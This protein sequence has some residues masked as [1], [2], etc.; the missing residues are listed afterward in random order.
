MTVEYAWSLAGLSGAIFLG[1][2][3][4]RIS[5]VG[6]ALVASP[7]LVVLLGPFNGILVINVF[8]VA[9]ALMVLVRVYREVEFTRALL[10]IVPAVIAIIPGSWVALHANPAFLSMMVGGVIIV[11]LSASV[12]VKNM[13]IFSGRTGAVVAGAISGF[14][15]VTAGVGGPALTAYAVATRWPQPAFAATAQL[16]FLTVGIV[17]LL[18]KQTMPRLDELQWGAS[19]GALLLGIAVGNVMS[20]RVPERA[21]R[22]AVISLAFAGAV[23]ILVKT[24]LLMATDASR[25]S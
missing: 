13:R 11:A 17:S 25:V 9:T 1:A 18:A 15:N 20:R 6:F 8:A 3:T 16:Y 10:M 23:L 12:L 4:Q 24:G 21:S 19:A 7:L 14:M 22:R 2:S 5:G